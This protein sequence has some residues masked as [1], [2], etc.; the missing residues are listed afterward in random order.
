M[1]YK[2]ISKN[3]QD[4][5]FVIE[6]EQKRQKLTGPKLMDK[7]GYAH[8]TLSALRHNKRDTAFRT[9][10]HILR[11]LRIP[12]HAELYYDWVRRGRPQLSSTISRDVSKGRVSE[13]NINQTQNV[14]ATEMR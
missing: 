12:S 3:A 9:V 1:A 13:P 11:V 6:L 2:P 8:D 14:V 10:Q 4:I 5:V 7:A